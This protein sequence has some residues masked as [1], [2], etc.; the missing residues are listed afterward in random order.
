LDGGVPEKRCSPGTVVKEEKMEIYHLPKSAAAYLFDMDSTLYTNPEYMRFQI[1]SPIKRLAEIRSLS[2]EA[3][4]Q[5]IDGY[6]EWWASTHNG[7]QVSLGN[8]FKAFG[9]PIEESVRWREDL[10]DPAAYLSRDPKLREIL[11][12]LK[13]SAVLAV[14]TN[15]PVLVARKT[16][17]V[18]GVEDCFHAVVG[19]DTCWVSK[20]HKAPFLKAAELC[21]AFPE[22]CVAV[23]DR[24]DID[25]ALPLKLGMGGVLVDGV[26]DV[27]RLGDL[28]QD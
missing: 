14:V 4:K 13:E 25:V 11:L 12:G 24:Y 15:N 16:L 26:E 23:G 20:P 9:V 19:L 17:A 27:Y 6:R 18:L 28:P 7:E 10:Y 3:M 5:A 1:E 22:T 8:A 21:G 2:F